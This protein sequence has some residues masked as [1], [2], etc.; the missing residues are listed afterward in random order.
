MKANK[1]TIFTPSTDE[2]KAV[3]STLSL[4]YPSLDA[5]SWVYPRVMELLKCGNWQDAK[6][7]LTAVSELNLFKE[8]P[9]KFPLVR[10]KRGN[11]DAL[12]M[13]TQGDTYIIIETDRVIV[14]FNRTSE[15]AAG[16]VYYRLFPMFKMEVV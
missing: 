11:V 16:M 13:E 4:I 10:R 14:D 6:D 3:T 12:V 15:T 8:H 1:I 2:F 9:S 5:P 7:L